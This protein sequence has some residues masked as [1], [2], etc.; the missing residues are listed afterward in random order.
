M[1]AGDSGVISFG[2][3]G[4]SN[5]F[6]GGDGKLTADGEAMAWGCGSIRAQDLGAGQTAC[7]EGLKN[8]SPRKLW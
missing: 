6:D 8:S 1:P 5:I 4:S 2:G 3:S 7:R